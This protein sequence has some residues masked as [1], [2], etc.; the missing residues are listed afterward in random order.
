MQYASTRKTLVR[1]ALCLLGAP[2]KF[3]H[4][5]ILWKHTEFRTGHC[6]VL[7]VVAC[8]EMQAGLPLITCLSLGVLVLQVRR[9]RRLVVSSIST[10]VNYEYG[11]F[12][13]STCYCIAKIS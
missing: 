5:G 4:T 9:M 2:S 3:V 6:E 8:E 10:I 11:F 7:F 13:Y 12:W 1:P